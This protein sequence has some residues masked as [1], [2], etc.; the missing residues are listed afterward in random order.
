MDSPPASP[1]PN[2]PELN[3]NSSDLATLTL[4]EQLAVHRKKESCNNCHQDIDPWGVPLENFDA[5]GRWRDQI[6]S[7]KKQPATPVDSTSTLPNGK[8]VKDAFDLKK[9]LFTERRQAFARSMVKRLMA[10][11]LG[12]SLDYAIEKPSKS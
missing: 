2:V 8:E 12:R 11:G 4:K 5:I 6:P 10:Y 7:H 9:Y 3:T 1:P